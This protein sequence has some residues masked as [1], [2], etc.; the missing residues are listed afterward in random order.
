MLFRSN[1]EIVSGTPFD[2]IHQTFSALSLIYIE[3]PAAAQMPVTHGL[4]DESFIRGKVPMTKSEI[5]SVILSKLKLTKAATLF[6]IGAGTGSIAI[7]AARQIPDGHVYAIERHPEGIALI[8]E[9]SHRLQVDNLTCIHGLAPDC[10][11]TLPVATHAFIGGS[12][13]HLKEI[14]QLLYS[15]NPE[16]QIVITAITLETISQIM[17]LQKELAFPEP[18]IIQIQVSSAR[19]AGPYHLMQGQNPIYII[20]F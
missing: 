2:F 6:D 9:N 10:L 3:N 14:L 8:K 18:E 11:E 19:K 5:R 7:E 4:T 16:I 12:A 13:G 15:Q 1:E 20:T 17:T